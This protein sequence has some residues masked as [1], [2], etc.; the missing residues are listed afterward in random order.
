MTVLLSTA[1]LD[2]AERCQEIVLIHQGRVLGQGDPKDLSK[3]MRGR[4]YQVTAPGTNKRSLQEKL[5][6]AP[7]ILDAI[8]QGGGVRVVSEKGRDASCG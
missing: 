7:G 1:Y 6:A 8:I 2:E 3:S 5:I 4:T